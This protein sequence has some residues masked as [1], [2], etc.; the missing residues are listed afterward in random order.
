M[1]IFEFLQ[2]LPKRYR[3]CRDK[4]FRERI[5]RVYFHHDGDGNRFMEGAFHV[6]KDEKTG[7]G[8]IICSNPDSTM[9]EAKDDLRQWDNRFDGEAKLVSGY[10]SAKGSNTSI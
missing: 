6:V 5:D 10:V 3:D 7:A 9:E 4:K 1:K 8:G 2:S